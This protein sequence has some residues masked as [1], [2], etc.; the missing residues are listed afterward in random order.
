MANLLKDI[1]RD[2]FCTG[3]QLAFLLLLAIGATLTVC[4][5]LW[6]IVWLL[7]GIR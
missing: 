5:P 7:G 2:V 6:G 4:A 1:L 3:K